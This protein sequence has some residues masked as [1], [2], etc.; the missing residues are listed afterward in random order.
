MANLTRDQVLQALQALSEADRTYLR[1]GTVGELCI[2]GQGGKPWS[3]D[4]GG[5]RPNRNDT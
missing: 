2:D 5:N 1:V 3:D 4:V